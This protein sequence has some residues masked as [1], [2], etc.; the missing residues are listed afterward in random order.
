M[1]T[2]N[3]RLFMSLTA[4]APLLLAGCD[5]TVSNPRNDAAGTYQLTVFAGRTIPATYT[6]AQGDPAFPSGG[7]FVVRSG[8][9]VLNSNGTFIETNNF[10][11]T[12]TGGSTQPSAFV[13]SGTWTIDGIDFTLSAPAQNNVG[14]RQVFGTLDIDTNNNY[15][16]HYTEDSGNGTFDAYEYRR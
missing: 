9:L 12:P 15:T 10:E 5:N 6:Y 8:S 7:T 16:V 2:R 1:L 11:T 14:P 13:S 3:A 4:A